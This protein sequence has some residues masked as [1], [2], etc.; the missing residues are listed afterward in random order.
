MATDY[1]RAGRIKDTNIKDA[2]DAGAEAMVFL[3]PLCFLSL[4]RRAGEAGLEPIPLIN[5]CRLALGEKPSA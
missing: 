1:E 2:L 4:R 3:C 5:L